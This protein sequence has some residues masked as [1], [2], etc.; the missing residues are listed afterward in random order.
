MQIQDDSYE[1]ESYLRVFVFKLLR[2]NL[3]CFIDDVI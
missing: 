2:E 3:L 1:N